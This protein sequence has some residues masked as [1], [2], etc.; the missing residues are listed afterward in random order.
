[1]TLCPAPDDQAFLFFGAAED[2]AGEMGSCLSAAG[3]RREMSGSPVPRE[4]VYGA[5]ALRAEEQSGTAPLRERKGMEGR[6][7][8]G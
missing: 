3:V 1:M 7:R 4:V 6:R 5:V 2:E 8:K